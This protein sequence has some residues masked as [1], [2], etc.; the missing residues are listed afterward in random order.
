M[1]TSKNHLPAEQVLE[2][3]IEN[4]QEAGVRDVLPKNV[5]PHTVVPAYLA[6]TPLQ[7]QQ[8]H[9]DSFHRNQPQANQ[10]FDKSTFSRPG[11]ADNLALIERNLELWSGT[12]HAYFDMPWRAP[13]A[14]DRVV[15]GDGTPD[16]VTIYEPPEDDGPGGEDPGGEDPGGEDPGGED[17][18]EGGGDGGEP[19]PQL[20]VTLTLTELFEGFFASFS[21]T[22]SDGTPPY[23][24][25]WDFGDGYTDEVL[26]VEAQPFLYNRNYGDT[27]GT[28]YATI[29][30]IDSEGV[31]GSDT[32]EVVTNP[33]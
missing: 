14:E 29:T 24:V 1:S 5:L 15:T 31:E 22:V 4:T 7:E 23:D 30:V 9:L 11:L 17:P 8:R 26:G 21:A 28:F 18:G 25:Y 10:G 3:H 6:E 16:T 13:Y 2:D 32:I 19:E 27:P 20:T 12:D 33:S